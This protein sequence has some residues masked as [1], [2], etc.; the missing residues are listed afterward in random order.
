MYLKDIEKA[1][2]YAQLIEQQGCED[3]EYFYL[4]A[5]MMLYE[6]YVFEADSYLQSKIPLLDG[7]DLD[8]FYLDV[9]FI[10][11]DYRLPEIAK[12]WLERSSEK[13]DP[14]Y[15]EAEGRIAL[16][17]EDYDKCETIFKKLLENEPF[18]VTLW[19][20]LAQAQFF[21]GR[22]VDSIDSSEYA[23]AINPNNAEALLN[24]AR[25]LSTM[26]RFSAATEYYERYLKLNPN[27]SAVR[28]LYA[29]SLIACGKFD[30]A[31]NNLFEA[32]NCCTD[33]SLMPEIVKQ[34]AFVLPKQGRGVEALALI[35]DAEKQGHI[36]R[37]DRLLNEGRLFLDMKE[38]KRAADCFLE[39]ILAS[40]HDLNAYMDVA[41]AYYVNEEFFDTINTLKAAMSYHCNTK[42]GYAYLAD[43]YR[44]QAPLIPL[45]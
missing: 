20:V 4:K 2:Y 32:K 45:Q 44:P 23:I 36:N 16:L 35:D 42:R 22:L 11:L 25:C 33:M 5:E 27:D 28:S 15:M 3:L 8:D 40:K 14:D 37:V 9:P 29:V 39:A 13:D 34:L 30:E 41:I 38:K 1:R 6:D 18:S 24:K 21:N 17:M 7:E 43:S 31:V 10:F 19:N 12:R 26:F